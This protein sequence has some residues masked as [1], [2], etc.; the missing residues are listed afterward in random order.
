MGQ[1]K[2]IKTNGNLGRRAPSV[3]GRA[4][5]I[6]TGVSV[7]GGLTLGTPY[8]LESLGDLE[9]LGVDEQYDTD[10]KVLVWHHVRDFYDEAP[11][12]TWLYLQVMAQTETIEKLVDKDVAANAKKLLNYADGNIRILGAAVSIP[13]GYISTNTGGFDANVLLAIPKAQ[14]LADDEWDLFRP[15]S[16]VIVEGR[17]MTATI[18]AVPDLRNLAAKAPNVSVVALQDKAVAN[19][20][21]LFAKHA[22]V[23]KALGVIART[24]V[25]ECIG[26]IG[27][28]PLTDPATGKFVAAALSSG[29]LVADLSYP[30][31]ESLDGKGV[32]FGR[33]YPRRAGVY[34]NDSHTCTLPTD[35]YA[36]IENNRTIDKVAI[37]VYD[38][39]LDDLNSPVSVD[40]QTG[41]LPITTTKYFE[42]KCYSATADMG[43]DG[44]VSD[45]SFYVDP[46][47]NILATS[48]LNI[49]AN[50]VPV[51][52][53]RQ[54][55]VKLGFQNPFNNA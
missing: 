49:E 42:N 50:V 31:M 52:V 23:G 51:G 30:E 5:L 34:F 46:E 16:A 27:A 15:L 40:G 35:D 48:V 41:Q 43:K 45:F 19:L 1:V 7:L 2:I 26:W 22:S 44:E 36:Q 20:D 32:I 55:N 47:Q 11:R 17:N 37:L 39:L 24:K 6:T 14:A 54:I 28:F 8:K 3:D 53:A 13:T 9:S 4:G 25:N 33:R 21:T 12:G 29:T 10:N 38:A 18:S